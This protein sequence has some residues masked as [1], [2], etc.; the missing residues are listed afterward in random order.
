[1]AGDTFCKNNT[2]PS[3]ARSGSF[4]LAA[5]IS[6]TASLMR[7]IAG[8]ERHPKA[9]LRKRGANTQECL[10][11]VLLIPIRRIG[12][13]LGVQDLQCQRFAAEGAGID[14]PMQQAVGNAPLLL[15]ATQC[16]R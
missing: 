8:S 7:V 15:P 4:R 13:T 1:M 12:L 5:L 10:S 11:P 6:A 2:A 9:P 16:D 14:H 3:A